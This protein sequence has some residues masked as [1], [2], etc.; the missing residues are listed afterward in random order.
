MEGY[1]TEYQKG[2]QEIS[3]S[4]VHI[5]EGQVMGKMQFSSE[6]QPSG[7]GLFLENEIDSCSFVLLQQV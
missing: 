2:E 3:E 7:F 4:K 5:Q 1:K 6:P